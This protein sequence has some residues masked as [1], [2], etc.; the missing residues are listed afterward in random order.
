[1]TT[2]PHRFLFHHSLRTANGFLK[3]AHMFSS[4]HI[5]DVL[6][7]P[8]LRRVKPLPK[9]RRTAIDPKTKDPAEATVESPSALASTLSAYY[10]PLL[11]AG[12]TALEDIDSRHVDPADRA[13]RD[14]TDSGDGD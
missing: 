8:A 1:M 5:F 3:S 11:G 9:R 10:R 13:G 4:Q 2:T 6:E 14:E 7:F 12:G